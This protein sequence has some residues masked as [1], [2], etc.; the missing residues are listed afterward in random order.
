MNGQAE[1][2]RPMATDIFVAGLGALIFVAVLIVALTRNGEA[3]R[4]SR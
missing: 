2:R 4:R 1:W 3:D